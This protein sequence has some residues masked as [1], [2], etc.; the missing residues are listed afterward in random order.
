MLRQ[1]RGRG[2]LGDLEPFESF[3]LA[4]PSGASG[5]RWQRGLVQLV[6]GSGAAPLA[7]SPGLSC[8]RR[9]V[10]AA[11]GARESSSTGRVDHAALLVEAARW[12]PG[13]GAARRQ[14][15]V[16]ARPAELGGRAVGA[17]WARRLRTAELAATP[18]A[19]ALSNEVALAARIRFEIKALVGWPAGLGLAPGLRSPGPR[20]NTS[21]A[22]QVRLFASCGLLV[23]LL[24]AMYTYIYIYI[25]T[26]GSIS[27]SLYIYIYICIRVCVYIYIYIHMLYTHAIFI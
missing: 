23:G 27:L 9:A 4:D 12:V 8:F 2:V 10:L 16:L 19:W 17:G 7:A 1:A 5:L 21:F 14:G 6:T 22:E 24:G 11:P 20:S 13:L 3:V 18:P 15:V 25:Y 26:H